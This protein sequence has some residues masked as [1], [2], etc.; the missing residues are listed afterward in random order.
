MWPTQ[1]KFVGHMRRKD[2]PPW[3]VERNNLYFSRSLGYRYK[4][5]RTVKRKDF[6]R[7]PRYH[8]SPYAGGFMHISALILSVLKEFVAKW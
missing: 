2:L 3:L 5:P 4:S 6:A 7:R 8:F 1:V